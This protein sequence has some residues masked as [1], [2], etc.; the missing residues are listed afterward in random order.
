MADSKRPSDAE[1]RRMYCDELLSSKDIGRALGVN[2]GTVCKWL[3]QAGIAVRSAGQ[4][5]RD[6]AWKNQGKS[7][8]FTDE[9]KAK[10]SAAGKHWGE[11]NAKGVCHKAGGYVEYTRGP[12][13]GRSVHVVLMEE[14][15]GRKLHPD[16]V[17]HHI[18]RNRQNNDISNL[19]LMTRNEHTRLHRLEDE[20]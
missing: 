20:R 14:H 16:E 9:W 17:V 5:S 6:F 1:L 11:A 13:K 18:D 2:H 19:R 7:R 10:L 15:I 3:H 4:G 12:H 8:T